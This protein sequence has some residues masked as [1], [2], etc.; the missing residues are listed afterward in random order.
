MHGL[1]IDFDYDSTKKYRLEYESQCDCAYCWNYYKTFRAKYLETT[2]LLEEFGLDIVFPLEI[3]PLQYD[4]LKNEK[5]YISFYPVKG[6]IDQDEIRVD[7]EGLIISIFKGSES[8]NP[9]PSP[10]MDEPYLLIGVSG[11][12]LPWVIDENPD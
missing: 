8:I 6:T 3:M 9:C 5:E 10:K 1:Q 11:I 2:K 7:L 4:E 12:K